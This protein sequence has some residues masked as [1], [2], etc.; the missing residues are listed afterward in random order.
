MGVIAFEA[1]VGGAILNGWVPAVPQWA[2]S[3]F[4]LLLFLSTNLVSTRSFGEVEYWLASIKVIAIV[5]FLGV[6][7]MF[8]FGLWP[9]STYSI[10]NLWQHGGFAPNGVAPI[11]TGVAVVI[12]SYF[13]NEIAVMAAAESEDPTRGVRQATR[14]VVWRIL[15][16]F[17]GGVTLIAVIVPWNQLPDPK[18]TPPFTYIFDLYGIPAAGTLMTAVILSAACSV[19]NSGMYS[20]GRMISALSERSLAPGFLGHRT[21]SGVPLWGVVSSTIGGF[22]AVLVNFAAPDSGVFDFIMNSAGLVALFVYAFIAASQLRMRSRMT[23][24]EVDA[25]PLKMWFHPWLGLLT[26]AGVVGVVIAMLFSGESGRTQVWT[27]LISVGVLGVIWPFVKSQ[28]RRQ[29]SAWL[30]EHPEER[31]GHEPES[32]TSAV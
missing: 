1:V 18:D 4:L 16:F 21:R 8:A 23:A 7:I 24:A 15:M 9:H 27:S 19:L 25:L 5:V 17:V 14:T 28:L 29:H 20:A 30:Q 32:R 3:V 11:I 6:G 12:F 2:F 22:A 26:I 10:P 13:G 31:S